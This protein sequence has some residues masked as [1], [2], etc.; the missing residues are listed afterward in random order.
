MKKH[1]PNDKR[2]ETE[3]RCRNSGCI[4]QGRLKI[5]MED[6]TLS[7]DSSEISRN[8]KSPE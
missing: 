3:V 4:E 2:R 1:Q 7:S 5:W 6:S 8:R